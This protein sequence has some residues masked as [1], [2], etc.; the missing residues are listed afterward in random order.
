MSPARAGPKHHPE[1]RM[2]LIRLILTKIHLPERFGPP[3]GGPERVEGPKIGFFL[4]RG[5]PDREKKFNLSPR[6]LGPPP[7][8]AGQVY[9][10]IYI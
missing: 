7:L 4:L 1:A 9:I 5:H 2:G 8:N 6:G 3:H 10:Y